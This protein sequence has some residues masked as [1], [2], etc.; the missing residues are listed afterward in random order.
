MAGVINNTAR[1]LTFTEVE[2][3]RLYTLP[4]NPGFNAVDDDHWRVCRKSDLLIQLVQSGAISVGDQI[5]DLEMTED[6]PNPTL[7]TVVDIP[8]DEPKAKPKARAKAKPKATA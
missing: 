3:G 7:S 2:E 4:L 5:D 8:K 6:A 1:I